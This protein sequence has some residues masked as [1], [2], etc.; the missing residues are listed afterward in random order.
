MMHRGRRFRGTCASMTSLLTALSCVVGAGDPKEDTA[1]E[2][3]SLGSQS[4]PPSPPSPPHTPQSTLEASDVGGTMNVPKEQA[5]VASPADEMA[6]DDKVRK[7]SPGR[8]LRE[9]RRM[10]SPN[11]GG[12]SCRWLTAPTPSQAAVPASPLGRV[13]G[14]AGLGA[15]LALGAIRD[16]AS[17]WFSGA[18]QEGIRGHPLMT[19]R[20]AERFADAL[21]RMRSVQTRSPPA[22][23]LRMTCPS[24]APPLSLM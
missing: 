24:S 17:S 8:K 18:P 12:S 21:C 13:V 10:G 2:A 9:V 14:F 19:E 22:P 16:S 23:H 4:P 20:N 3:P 5:P 1:G 6:R 7:P 11:C 15:S